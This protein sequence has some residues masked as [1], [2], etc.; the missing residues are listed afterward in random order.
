MADPQRGQQYT[1][2]MNLID[3]ATGLLLSDPTIAAGDFQ[4]SIDGGAFAS[5]GSDPVVSPSGSPQLMVTLSDS[6]MEGDN[7]SLWAVDAAGDEWDSVFISITTTSI[8]LDT[9][10][11]GF[12][13]AEILAGIAA[14]TMGVDGTPSG[15]GP[16][17]KA[18]DGSKTRITSNADRSSVTL[19]LDD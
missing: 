2:A 16:T 1:F 13:I 9:L 6:E 14:A 7:I 15:T 17:Y 5:M 19:D 18:I 3:Q 12:T 4:V 11:D 8:T 10:I